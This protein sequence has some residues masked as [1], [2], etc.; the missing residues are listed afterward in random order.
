MDSGSGV[1]WLLTVSDIGRYNTKMNKIESFAMYD[2]NSSFAFIDGKRI[3][4]GCFGTGLKIFNT[5]TFKIE[6]IL[7]KGVSAKGSC[8]PRNRE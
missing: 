8:C 3:L 6:S 7:I 2:S 5:E 4:I 1:I